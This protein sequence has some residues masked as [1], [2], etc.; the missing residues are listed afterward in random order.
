M[1]G[2]VAKYVPAHMIKD[3]AYT[4]SDTSFC[5][6][7]SKA[8]LSP[9]GYVAYQWSDGL[10][11]STHPV[12]DATPYFVYCYPPSCASPVL[13]DTFS[14]NI[15]TL[16]TFSLGSDT[17]SC[18]PF[19][20]MAPSAYTTLLW[21]D[22][23]TADSYYVTTTGV[24]FLTE[25]DGICS[26]TD[27]ILVTIDSTPC[28]DEKALMPNV[29]TPNNDGVNDIIKPIFEHVGMVSDYSYT[30]YDRSGALVFSSTDPT[31]GWD[32]FINSRKAEVGVYVYNLKYRAPNGR[33]HSTNGNITLLR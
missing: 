16:R 23:S 22:S 26:F 20:L 24:Y 31:R 1:D 7:A 13:V 8:L 29:F 21:Q 19:S 18:I 2:Y 12:S 4:H 6:S 11:A 25:S 15:D 10:W 30:I 28:S 9:I 33:Y 32:G 5:S 27:S 3:T 14:I 17:A